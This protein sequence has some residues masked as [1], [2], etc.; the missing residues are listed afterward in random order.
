MF[1]PI[2]KPWFLNDD[3]FA[4][5]AGHAFSSVTVEF[6]PE[7]T[8][9]FLDNGW[10]AEFAGRIVSTT[11]AGDAASTPGALSGRCGT[12]KGRVSPTFVVIMLAGPLQGN[13]A[14]PHPVLVPVLSDLCSTSTAP[15][16]CLVVFS[17]LVTC[18]EGLPC[19]ANAGLVL[20]DEATSVAP[21]VA[22]MVT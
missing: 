9:W 3:D 15:A 1:V 8:G 10:I 18:R 19:P 20:V 5:F 17:G 14:L 13:G 2:T 6:V 12:C 16:A 22:D 21:E 7:T 4:V 11:V